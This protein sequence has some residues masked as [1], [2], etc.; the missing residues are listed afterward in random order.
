MKIGYT[1]VMGKDISL[2]EEDQWLFRK[3]ILQVMPHYNYA[4]AQ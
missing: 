2:V 1:I 4:M 3:C